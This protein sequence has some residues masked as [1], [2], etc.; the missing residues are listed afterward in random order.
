MTHVQV[1]EESTSDERPVG[2]LSPEKAVEAMMADVWILALDHIT[3]DHKLYKMSHYG[4]VWRDDYNPHF[5]YHRHNFM[6]AFADIE[7]FVEAMKA[8]THITLTVNPDYR[9]K[10]AKRDYLDELIR[11]AEK[12]I[13]GVSNE[14]DRHYVAM[15][16]AANRKRQLVRWFVKILKKRTEGSGKTIV[17]S[18]ELVEVLNRGKDEIKGPDEV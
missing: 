3:H 2:G 8:Q 18:K 1:V 12:N 4:Q 15:K 10:F 16:N 9:E 6:L 14:I 17:M 13:V 11:N 7:S 5:S